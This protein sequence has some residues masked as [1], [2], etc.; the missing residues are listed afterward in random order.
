MNPSAIFKVFF[1]GPFWLL[2]F[3]VIIAIIKVI[4]ENRTKL[5]ASNNFARTINIKDCYIDTLI[6]ILNND[7]DYHEIIKIAN[8]T[9]FYIDE[10]QSY[11]LMFKNWTGNLKGEIND[12]NWLIK[13]K[14]DYTVENVFPRLQR[15]KTFVE[16]NLNI[17]TESI[18]VLNNM[19]SLELFDTS[20]KIIRIDNIGDTVKR[21]PIN[22]KYTKDE[23]KELKN[24]LCKVLSKVLQ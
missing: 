6:S 16:G 8:D 23:I 21:K 2:L 10:Y 19:L 18:L 7:N 14:E 24:T 9:I 1:Y 20:I 13:S 4:L 22:K 3:L 17:E 5:R 12:K 15:L 11:V